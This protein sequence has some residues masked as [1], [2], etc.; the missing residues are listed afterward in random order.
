[1]FRLT[2]KNIWAYKARL[3]LSMLSVVLG[4]TFLCGT[5]VIS[6][7]I[8]SAID[9]IFTS[10]YKKTDV[11]VRGVEKTNQNDFGDAERDYI[12]QSVLADV[13]ANP[14][15]K[16]AEGEIGESNLIV[17][18]TKGL[19]IFSTQGPPTLGS[20]L[21]KVAELSQW[22]K[23]AKNGD[24]ISIKDTIN[25]SLAD[26]EV[27]VDKASAD[28]QKFKI[29][30]KVNIVT[31]TDV[32]T[33]KIV[34]FM[35]FGSA[36]G[37]GGAAVFFFNDAQ[38]T[39]I[40]GQGDTYQNINVA[41]K[42]GV[43]QEEAEKNI[44]AALD[45][46]YP[47]KYEAI[48]G[49]KLI[50][51]SQKNIQEVLT[52][53]TVGLLCF[54]VVS[55]LVA[56]VIIINSFAIILAQRKREYAL[57]RAIGATGGQIRRS[58][59][60]ES[61]I[62]GLISSAI[63]VL[64]GIGLSAGLKALMKA[65]EV[66]LPE[67]P[68]VIPNSSII[69]GMV[70]GTVATVGSAFFPAWV[71]SRVPPIEA[72]RDSAFE[73]APKWFRRYIFAAVVL[74]IA[75]FTV[76]SG[77]MKPINRQTIGIG[78]VLV[79]V[80]VVVILPILVKPFTKIVGSKVA[81]VIL[82]IF[83]G[84]RA[85][86]ITGEV[87]RRNNYRNPKRSARTALALMI[88]VA[89]VVFITVFTASATSTFTNYLKTNYAAD[90]IVGDFGSLPTSL[91]PERCKAID[92]ESY[93]KTSSCVTLARVQ[94]SPTSELNAGEQRLSS[95]TESVVG[96]K[97]EKLTTLFTMKYKGELNDLGEDGIAVSKDVAKDQKIGIG[98]K[99]TLEGDLSK[100]VLTV[101][102]VTEEGLLGPGGDAYII[103]SKSLNKIQTARA[104]FVSMVVVKDSASPL[105][106]RASLQT[107]LKNTGI[108]VNDLKTVRDQQV[109]QVNSFLNIFYALLML[110][111][112]IATI[113]ILNTMSLSILE[114]RRELGLM[115][116]VGTTKAQVR[117][118][119]RFESV[120]LAVLG[121]TVGMLFGIGCGWLFIKSL[122]DEGFVT[123]SVAPGT[124]VTIL[125]LSALIGIIAGAWPAWRATKV[126]VLKAITVE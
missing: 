13:Q 98:D 33:Y 64:G 12:P 53:L 19:K 48:T 61:S 30:T 45:K 93:I 57:L 99:V 110:A 58:V 2:L 120:I 85:F 69:I 8:K 51:D 46:K 125:F 27:L 35:R 21:P 43:T 122:K 42:D 92:S 32:R 118:F 115:R 96:L 123:F 76:V 39:H 72:L 101:K 20:A 22:H 106:A 49:K 88:G 112:V 17:L 62:L 103:D 95:K 104:A 16:V 89:L 14:D 126:D 55:F 73:K 41:V 84:R 121:T 100:K 86:G 94:F 111:I 109:D 105:D 77:F 4:V 18:D 29:G 75:V 65:L 78:M 7:T 34:G 90:I 25:T 28:A 119:V 54:S 91:S 82:V 113:G 80:F 37:V 36:D 52:F 10:L 3:A 70:V 81:G 97:T 47:G 26:D 31:K 68:L 66:T 71:A 83:G 60:A 102:A 40:A 79:G 11:Q 124:L 50:K 117:G 38:I 107:L 6:A 15:V 67:G 44:Q 108:D 87:A 116:A 114:R 9:D 1:M 59:F 23:V 74:A 24:S 56:L 63:G 5:L